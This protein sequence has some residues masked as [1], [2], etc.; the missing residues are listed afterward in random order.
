MVDQ[1]TIIVSV[2]LSVVGIYFVA[3]MWSNAELKSTFEKFSKLEAKQNIRIFNSK[4][5]SVPYVVTKRLFDFIFSFFAMIFLLPI[6]LVVCILIKVDSKGPIMYKQSR[7]GKNGKQFFA[8]KFRT[9]IINAK[10]VSSELPVRRD[11]RITRVGQFLRSTNIDE[12]PAFISVL[13]GDMTLVGRSRAIEYHII[14][15][16]LSRE[17]RETLLN[18]KPGL[19]SLWAVSLNRV[20]FNFTGIYNY[21]FY[22]I[23]K[24][25]FPFDLKILLGAFIIM[26]GSVSQH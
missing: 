14:Y 24:M 10:E 22:Y 19:V 8:Y 12:L 7:M 9:M 18:I 5:V 13:R 20:E 23:N 16:E 21:D 11:P 1:I 4:H 2:I 25:S 17:Q 3:L 6:L 26:F 15:D